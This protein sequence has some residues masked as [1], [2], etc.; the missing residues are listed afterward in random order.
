MIFSGV[1]GFGDV[2]AGLDG[3]TTALAQDH[4]KVI[5]FP[6]RDA[7]VGAGTPSCFANICVFHG[8]FKFLLNGRVLYGRIFAKIFQQYIQ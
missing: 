6:L 3:A 1:R 5:L 4:K 7:F 8:N 2:Q